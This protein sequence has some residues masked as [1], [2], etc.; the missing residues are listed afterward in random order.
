MRVVA[1][2]SAFGFFEEPR[3]ESRG[4]RT[5]GAPV[6][7]QGTREQVVEL[8]EEFILLLAPFGFELGSS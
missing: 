5:R 7:L 3:A 6:A 4:D 8:G 2:E 1:A